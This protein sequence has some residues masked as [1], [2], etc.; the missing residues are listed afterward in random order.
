MVGVIVTSP[1]LVPLSN[2]QYKSVSSPIMFS[3]TQ[4]NKVK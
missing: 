4:D 3:T 2:A 1:F